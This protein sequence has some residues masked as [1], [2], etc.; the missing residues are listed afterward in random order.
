MRLSNPS[1]PNI[2]GNVGRSKSLLPSCSSA[3]LVL[4]P[5]PLGHLTRNIQ[6][7]CAAVNV[8]ARPILPFGVSVA[9]LAKHGHAN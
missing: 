9:S 1:S 3:S 5:G 7:Q 8:E 2:G 6:I 4:I